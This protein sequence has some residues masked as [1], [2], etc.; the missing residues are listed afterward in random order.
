MPRRALLFLLLAQAASGGKAPKLPTQPDI[1]QGCIS[2][3]NIHSHP[4]SLTTD[5]GI[6][7]VIRNDCAEPVTAV[8]TVAYLDRSGT[9]FG[10]GIPSATVDTA[11]SWSFSYQPPLNLIDRKRLALIKIIKVLAIQ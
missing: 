11:T 2:I 1:T 9:Q 8:I 4:R 7:A 10:D 3:T 6:E 5:P